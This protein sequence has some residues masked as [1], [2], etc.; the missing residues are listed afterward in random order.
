MRPSYRFQHQ[1]IR[2]ATYQ[3]LL[4]QSRAVLHELFVGWAEGKNE[5]RDR[6][7]E[8]DEILGYH[9]EQ[10]YRCWRELGRLDD[11]AVGPRCGRLRAARRRRDAGRWPAATCTPP[12]TS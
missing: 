5:D 8:F 9:L 3:G 1:L 11:H 10:A 2:D 7:A 12:P 6:A 4:K